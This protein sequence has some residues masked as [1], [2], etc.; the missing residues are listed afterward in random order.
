MTVHLN[1][2]KS[3]GKVLFIVE[4]GRTEPFLIKKIF[5]DILG[6]SMEQIL[7]DKPY[8]KYSSLTNENSRVFVVNAEESNIKFI[9]RD[10]DF[11]NNLFKEL[12]ENYDFDLDNSA[13]FYVFDRDALSNVDIEC[14]QMLVSELRNSRDN[15]GF[16][17]QGLLL[18]SYPSVESFTMSNFVEK[19][20]DNKYE[21]GTELKQD[22]NRKRIIQNAISPESLFF[23]IK[24][25]FYGFKQMGIE[26]INLDDFMLENKKVFDFEQQNFNDEN[27]FFAFSE[28]AVILLD[29]GILEIE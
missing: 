21:T 11:L 7:R 15:P 10:N 22:L 24:E 25:L 8:R 5:V 26:S 1:R 3:I 18:V 9:R 14:Y 20:F 27:L 29:L 28:F 23:A 16:G 4:G 2:N 13:I 12:I 19:T 17:R 6:Y